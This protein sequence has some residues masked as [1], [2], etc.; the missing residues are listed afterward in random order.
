LIEVPA[1]ITIDLLGSGGVKTKKNLNLATSPLE[2]GT[3]L[4][5]A[6]NRGG[7]FDRA[8]ARTVIMAIRQRILN[9]KMLPTLISKAQ[10]L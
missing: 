7:D 8:N 9:K 5:P 2:M 6:R 10:H 3:S 1:P 4:C